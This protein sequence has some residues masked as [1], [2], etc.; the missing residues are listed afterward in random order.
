MRGCHL[1][2]RL[3]DCHLGGRL[4]GC[5]FGGRLAVAWLPGCH[6]IGRLQRQQV[7]CQLWFDIPGCMAN[8]MYCV[9]KITNVWQIYSD[10]IFIIPS[11]CE[12]IKKTYSCFNTTFFIKRYNKSLHV[13]AAIVIFSIQITNIL[14]YTAH[15]SFYF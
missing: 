8:I 12:Q 13:C 7:A 14:K 4:P 3:P 11:L 10:S 6:Q 2:G 15:Y 5:H 1:G 9:I